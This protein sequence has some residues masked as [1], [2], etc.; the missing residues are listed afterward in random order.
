METLSNLEMLPVAPLPTQVER[1][2]DF[3]CSVTVG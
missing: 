2:C 3:T 1:L